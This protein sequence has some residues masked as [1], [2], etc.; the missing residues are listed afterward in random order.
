M[1]VKSQKGFDH[2]WTLD[3]NACKGANGRTVVDC[4]VSASLFQVVGEHCLWCTVKNSTVAKLKLTSVAEG[5][6]KFAQ[7]CKKGKL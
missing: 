2:L 5:L 1:I 4:H 6:L 7:K 3:F